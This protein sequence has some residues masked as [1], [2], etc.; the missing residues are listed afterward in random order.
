[1]STEKS[2]LQIAANE[3]FDL[4]FKWE[5]VKVLPAKLGEP[6]RR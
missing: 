2:Q 1:M 5:V 6:A 4:D 3:G